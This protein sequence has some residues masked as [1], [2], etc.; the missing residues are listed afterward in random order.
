MVMRGFGEG[1]QEE[2]RNQAKIIGNAARYLTSAAKGGIST[3]S[4]D[5]RRTYNNTSSVTL[6]VAEMNVR[7]KQDIRSLAVE[8]A[9]LTRTQQRGK[10]L[11]MA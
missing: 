7:D 9:G 2:T 11:R 1:I 8:I 5:N 3:G 4:T 10:G 6:Q